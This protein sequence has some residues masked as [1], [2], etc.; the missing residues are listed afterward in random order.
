MKLQFDD[1]WGWLGSYLGPSSLTWP[2]SGVARTAKAAIGTSPFMLAA[3]AS[4]QDGDLSV[5]GLLSDS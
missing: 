2:C 5:V 4:L 3:W 1:D